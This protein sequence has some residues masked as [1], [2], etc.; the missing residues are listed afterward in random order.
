MYKCIH[1]ETLNKY[2]SEPE[3]PGIREK[4]SAPLHDGLYFVPY[5]EKNAIQY[6]DSHEKEKTMLVQVQVHAFTFNNKQSHF[7]VLLDLT[8]QH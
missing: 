2:V 8:G 3:S 6:E 4:Q 1:Q 5:I 7:L